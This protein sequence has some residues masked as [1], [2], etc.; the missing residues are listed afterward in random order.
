MCL[1]SRWPGFGNNEYAHLASYGEIVRNDYNLNIPRYV[2]TFEEETKID[3]V[4]LSC[5]TADLNLQIKQKEAEF[6]AL[7]DELAITDETKQLIE[8]TKRIFT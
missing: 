2:D 4:A 3:I 1:K 8:T 5:E 6:S 7:L